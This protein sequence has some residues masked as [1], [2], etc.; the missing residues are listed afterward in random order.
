ALIASFAG[1]IAGPTRAESSLPF[2]EMVI[3][4][5]YDAGGAADMIARK[6]A[7]ELGKNL[8]VT[9]IV[10]NRPGAG[11]IIGSNHVAQAKPDGSVLLLTATNHVINP[12]TR[13]SLPYD[14]IADFTPIGLVVSAA[15]VLFINPSIPANT[16]QEFIALAKEKPG[17]LTFATNSVGSGNHLSGELL[18]LMAGFDMTHVS[19]GGGA[20]GVA[21]VLGNHV[22]AGF[23]S[24]PNVQ[25]YFQDGQLKALAVTGS[26]RLEAAPEIPT[27]AESGLDGYETLSIFVL[28]GPAGMS[29][30]T[31]KT[32]ENALK[33]VMSNDEIK[34]FFSSQGLVVGDLYG[35]EFAQ[36]IEAE[37]KKWSS[38]VENAGIEKQ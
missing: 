10:E 37:I 16:L 18:K 35:A 31:E 25:S 32:I 28:L 13:K 30:E 15:N 21:A 1:L 7:D 6:V 29:E 38:V 17:T 34:Q 4:S 3:V 23:A 11:T 19:Y 36:Y 20:Q 5:P 12:A 2:N 26:E 8:G 33:E 14:T 27:V 24:L 9:A 22:S